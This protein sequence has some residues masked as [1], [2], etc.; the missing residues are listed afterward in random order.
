MP[1]ESFQRH[2]GGKPD[3]GPADYRQLADLFKRKNDL[4]V[5]SFQAHW[6]G[7]IT[8]DDPFHRK[9]GGSL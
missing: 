1:F 2:Y 5:E 3:W 6:D 8:T 7:Y 4:T 9:Q